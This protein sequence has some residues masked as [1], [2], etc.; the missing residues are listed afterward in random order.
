MFG[1]AAMSATEVRR[2]GLNLLD[3]GILRLPTGDPRN[4]AQRNARLRHDNRPLALTGIEPLNNKL[5]D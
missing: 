4:G 5:M 3:A 2:E 1:F